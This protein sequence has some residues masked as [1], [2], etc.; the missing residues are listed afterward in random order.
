[1]LGYAVKMRKDDDHAAG[2]GRTSR[3]VPATSKLAI[4]EVTALQLA[5][6]SGQMGMVVMLLALAE[7]G[8]DDRGGFTKTKHCSM[9]QTCVKKWCMK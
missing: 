5:I 1:M 8:Q 9:E 4:M 2:G 6:L 7:D 3:Y